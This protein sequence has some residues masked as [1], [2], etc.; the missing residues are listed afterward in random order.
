MIPS[1]A[2]MP[3]ET[4]A[5]LLDMDRSRT[6]IR[7]VTPTGFEWVLRREAARPIERGGF[8]G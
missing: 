5:H 3:V 8:R 1:H 2:N 4:L 7:Y 6:C